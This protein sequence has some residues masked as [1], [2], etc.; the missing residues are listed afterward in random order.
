MPCGGRAGVLPKGDT[1]A[2]MTLIAEHLDEH[3]DKSKYRY[4]F[5]RGIPLEVS[6][7]YALGSL[8][9]PLFTIEFDRKDHHFLDNVDQNGKNALKQFGVNLG[10]MSK[11]LRIPSLSRKAI[12]PP[13][14]KKEKLEKKHKSADG[15]RPKPLPP[16]LNKL[17]NSKL[18]IL[19]KERNLSTEGKKAELI[20]RLVEEG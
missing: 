5:K 14:E 18:Q 2:K 15:P 10:S 20:K 4:R 8:G 7:S 1:M 19:L 6:P 13:L 17:T 9:N 3:I 12:K 11:T 16:K